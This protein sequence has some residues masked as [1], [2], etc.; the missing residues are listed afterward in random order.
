MLHETGA[1]LR[2]LGLADVLNPGQTATTVGALDM[3]AFIDPGILLGDRASRD[4]DIWSLG[5]TLHQ[6]LTGQG[7]FG[8]LPTDPLAAIRKMIGGAP[9]PHAS[10]TEDEARVITACIAPKGER[11]LTAS[12]LADDL[13]HLVS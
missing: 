7:L 10:L 2:D 5:A 11:Y 13:D 4:S 12:A 9:A 1:K 3:V 8:D 6:A